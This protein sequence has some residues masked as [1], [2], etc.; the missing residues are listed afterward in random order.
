MISQHKSLHDGQG[1]TAAFVCSIMN[2]YS[3]T[4]E[5][6]KRSQMSA[7]FDCPEPSGPGKCLP[8]NL[9]LPPINYAIKF[10]NLQ[11]VD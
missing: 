10:A 4:R 2:T 9:W 6:L 11:K 8:V 5:N 1:C 3:V 7:S